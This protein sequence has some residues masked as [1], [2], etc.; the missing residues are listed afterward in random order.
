M[1]SSRLVRLTQSIV[2]TAYILCGGMSEPTYQSLVE[3]AKRKELHKRT[4]FG[5]MFLGMSQ[6]N[7]ENKKFNKS[8]TTCRVMQTTAKLNDGAAVYS[9]ANHRVVLLFTA[10]VTAGARE[11]VVLGMRR[12]TFIVL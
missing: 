11:V 8:K 9:W 6:S 1:S 5:I 3:S 2:T 4:D 12:C 10:Q 7:Q